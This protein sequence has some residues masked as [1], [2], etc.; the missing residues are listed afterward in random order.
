[1]KRSEKDSLPSRWDQAKAH[2]RVNRALLPLKAVMFLFYGGSI[3]RFADIQ[4]NPSNYII[5]F[6]YVAFSA[7]LLPYITL[8]MLQIGITIEEVGIIYAVLPFASCLGPP[9]AG[10]KKIH[11]QYFYSS[12]SYSLELL[13]FSMSY[14]AIAR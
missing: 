2:L 8:H 11:S 10:K 5:I 12:L 13:F 4:S 1:M 3:C 9:I 14:I 6:V 7:V